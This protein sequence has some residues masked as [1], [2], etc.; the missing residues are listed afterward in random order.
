MR[1]AEL[2]GYEVV[3]EQHVPYS[4]GASRGRA[5]VVVYSLRDGKRVPSCVIELKAGKRNTKQA[6]ANL[7]QLHNEACEKQVVM[8]AAALADES[9]DVKAFVVTV[10]YGPDDQVGH[11]ERLFVDE[12]DWKQKQ[13]AHAAVSGHTL[14]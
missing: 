8:Y 10:A 3:L 2:G 9:P 12:V 11:G 14:E 5:D 7:L 6:A 1:A 13:Q 4:D